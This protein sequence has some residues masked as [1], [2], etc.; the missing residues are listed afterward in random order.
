MPV[1]DMAFACSL[2]VAV[3][4]SLLDRLAAFHA[5]PLIRVRLCPPTNRL[6]PTALR[7]PF[8]RCMLPRI[9]Y[10]FHRQFLCF[11][12]ILSV[13][14]SISAFTQLICFLA[15]MLGFS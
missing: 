6:R 10:L 2:G 8:R 13:A 3:V 7:S 1:A 9:L 11:Y 4:S 12:W 14:F 15:A 5:L